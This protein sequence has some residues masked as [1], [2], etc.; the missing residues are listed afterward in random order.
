MTHYEL[1]MHHMKVVPLAPSALCQIAKRKWIGTVMVSCILVFPSTFFSCKN[2]M[3][4]LG[5]TTLEEV[6]LGGNSI[7]CAFWSLSTRGTS[8]EVKQLQIEVLKQEKRI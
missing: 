4:I 2:D 1:K 7:S 5:S 8:L 6:T 3:Q